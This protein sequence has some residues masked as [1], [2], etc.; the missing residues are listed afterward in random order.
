MDE[1]DRERD[2]LR[3]RISKT[4]MNVA[5]TLLDPELDNMAEILIALDEVMEEFLIL[6]QELR[7]KYSHERLMRPP[8]FRASGS[9]IPAAPRVPKITT[10]PG[11]PRTNKR[12]TM[13][14]IKGRRR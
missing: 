9:T 7:E 13:P 12:D 5:S 1:I 6:R 4:L 10:T 8:S 14:P 2:L 11:K 3:A